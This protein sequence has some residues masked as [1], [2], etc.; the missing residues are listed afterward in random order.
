MTPARRR[1]NSIKDP[2]VFPLSVERK[3]RDAWKKIAAANGISASAMF[4]AL[5][6][7]IQLTE[8]GRPV[9]LPDYLPDTAVVS[10]PAQDGELNLMT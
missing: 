7:N 4:D 8:E 5:V 6:A 2:V 3:N 9:W 1:R 10:R